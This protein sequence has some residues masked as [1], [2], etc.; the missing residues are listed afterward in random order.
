MV[1]NIFWAITLNNT[2]AGVILFLI[3]FTVLFLVILFKWLFNSR[4][5]SFITV[6]NYLIVKEN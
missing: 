6:Y 4:L 3:E 2:V 5:I 1:K